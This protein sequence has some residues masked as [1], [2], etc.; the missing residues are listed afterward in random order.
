LSFGLNL[1]TFFKIIAVVLL[2]VWLPATQH[3]D[4]EAAGIEF[5]TLGDH[6]AS[7]SCQDVCQDD[8][9]HTIEGVSYGKA[10]SDLRVLPPPASFAFCLLSL[11]VAPVLMER[12]PVCF[13][14][15]SPEIQALHR[16]WQFVRR[17]ALPARAPDCVA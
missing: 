4:L 10:A 6:H 17:T 7:S 1:K 5:I 12:E 14:G 9:C 2:A 13:T 8:A 3:C 11:L 16:T 15:D